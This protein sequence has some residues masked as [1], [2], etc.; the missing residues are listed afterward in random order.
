[1]VRG[2]ELTE[3]VS[4]SPGSNDIETWSFPLFITSASLFH[5]EI[6]ALMLIVLLFGDRHPLRNTDRLMRQLRTEIAE[7][8]LKLVENT[9]QFLSIFRSPAKRQGNEKLVYRLIRVVLLHG[10]L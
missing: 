4:H 3:S 2:R 7:T 5:L 6:L 1:M 10:N 9:G 8:S